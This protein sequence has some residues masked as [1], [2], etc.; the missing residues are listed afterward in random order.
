L[1][2]PDLQE[3]REVKVAGGSIFI[4]ILKKNH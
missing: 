2:D 3:M 4:P 1:E